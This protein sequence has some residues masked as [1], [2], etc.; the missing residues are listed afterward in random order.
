MKRG[1]SLKAPAVV[2][3]SLIVKERCRPSVVRSSPSA[4][5]ETS[6]SVERRSAGCGLRG[7]GATMIIGGLL[8]PGPSG[9]AGDA[10]RGVTERTLGL[11]RKSDGLPYRDVE[12]VE[13][14]RLA[15]VVNMLKRNGCA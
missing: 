6:S 11:K 1:R 13:D 7:T 14:G 3:T 8:T 5:T 15:G 9:H 12:E 2:S 10:E 4:K